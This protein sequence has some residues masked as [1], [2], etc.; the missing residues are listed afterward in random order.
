MSQHESFRSPGPKDVIGLTEF[1]KSGGSPDTQWSM[2]ELKIATGYIN[3]WPH[4][5]TPL[6]RMIATKQHD[7]ITFLLGHGASVDFR[8]YLGRTPLQEAARLQYYE[9]VELLLAHG[10]NP[11]MPSTGQTAGN[12]IGDHDDLTGVDT[13]VMPIH[14]SLVNGDTR[15][16]R[17]LARAGVDLNQVSHGWRPLDLALIDRQVD[18]IDTLVELGAWFSSAPE[19]EYCSQEKRKEAAQALLQFA[20]H[21]D[22]FPPQ[23]CYSLFV[24]VL[25]AC[26]ISQCIAMAHDRKNGIRSNELIR[27]F[28]TRVSSIAE[29]INIEAA[30]DTFCT[31]CFRY[32]THSSHPSCSCLDEGASASS[33]DC[34][35]HHNSLENLVSSAK[36]GCRLCRLLLQSL[37]F[38]KNH[39]SSVTL[40]LTKY[41][42]LP[43]TPGVIIH[44]HLRKRIIITV[45]NLAAGL[46]LSYLNETTIKESPSIDDYENGT[47][48]L[49]S[50]QVAKTWLYNCITN[51]QSCGSASGPLPTRVIDV[52]DDSRD[53]F[54]LESKGAHDRYC[55]LS[56]CWGTSSSA[57]QT[58]TANLTRYYEAIPPQGLP[59][60]LV[61]AIHATRSLGFRYIWIDALCIIQDDDEDWARE[62]VRMTQV[63]ANATL[64]ITTTVGKSSDDGLFR[65]HPDGFFNPQQLHIRLPRRDRSKPKTPI[66]DIDLAIVH[67]NYPLSYL[68]VY[69]DANFG[70]IGYAYIGAQSTPIETRA[71]TLQEQIL[72]KRLLYY[73][74]GAILWECLET[75]ASEHDPDG[76]RNGFQFPDRF[77]IKQ[78]FHSHMISNSE[79]T[80]A[81][82]DSALPGSS[83]SASKIAFATYCRLLETYSSRSITKPSDRITAIL[84]LGQIMQRI[85]GH[86]F[87]GGIWKGE[88]TLA[89]LLWLM[90]MPSPNAR[91]SSFPTWSWASVIPETE[92][93][94][95]VN[96]ISEIEGEIQW[97][98]KVASFDAKSDLAQTRVTG[99]ITIEGP[100]GKLKDDESYKKSLEGTLRMTPYVFMDLAE[101]VGALENDLDNIWCLDMLT[102]SGSEDLPSKASLLLRYV[103]TADSMTFQRIGLYQHVI[104]SEWNKVQTVNLF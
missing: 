98:A 31:P 78:Y 70:Y 34:F 35:K 97:K 36:S 60:T 63:Y 93:H 17:I 43:T 9:G 55:A 66:R 20:S 68:A 92:E 67:S 39:R 88:N 75:S 12:E 104:S 50:F 38:V 81:L 37:N 13:C 84:G 6:H 57:H 48:S 19:T 56:Y 76:I 100:L 82:T 26:D 14:E 11:S 91:T 47:S 62:A 51:H 102:L 87:I 25:A 74:H 72:S 46:E 52:G 21:G 5:N 27:D 10:A 8:N 90:E 79:N 29:S 41:L 73:G 3:A 32:Q 7:G 2:G 59:R 77:K 86:E 53:P 30:E 95:V 40:M 42:Q 54:L 15:M 45:G 65:A 89:S 83:A 1:L 71:W 101:D 18:V 4:W 80:K 16:I 99:S 22:W 94:R 58:T 23:S 24:S 85:S 64:T 49:S 103:E 44:F 28:F 61:D 96:N 33:T 69:P